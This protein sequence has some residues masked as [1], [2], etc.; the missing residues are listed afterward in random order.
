MIRPE[1]ESGVV[2]GSEIMKKEKSGGHRFRVDAVGI[3][4]GSPSQRLRP[5]S[6]PT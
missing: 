2:F 5:T 1:R 3:V 4:K 6:R